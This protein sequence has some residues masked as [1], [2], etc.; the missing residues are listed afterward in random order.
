MLENLKK[1][2]SQ[3]KDWFANSIKS[4]LVHYLQFSTQVNESNRSITSVPSCRSLLE[5]SAVICQDNACLPFN[6]N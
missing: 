6:N 5:T 3:L 2:M 4:L 1:K